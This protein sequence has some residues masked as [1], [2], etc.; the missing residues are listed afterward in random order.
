[1]TAFVK[2]LEKITSV[3]LALVLLCHPTVFLA[4]TLTGQNA[5]HPLLSA[6]EGPARTSTIE[7]FNSRIGSENRERVWQMTGPFGGDVTA[8]AIDPR[9]ADRVLIGGSDG[10]LFQS[11]NGG[12]SWQR[13][14][15]G[16]K[17]PGFSITVILF[18]QE[19]AG[20]IYVG[21]KP[22]LDLDAETN[23]GGLYVSADSGAN[24]REVEG[25]RGR[26]IRTLAQSAKDKN[27]LLAVSRNAVYRSANR[28]K[29]WERITP[30]DDPE[31]RNFHS[32]AIDP[33]DTDIIYVGTSHLP[34]KTKDGGK[35][36][37]RAGTKESGMIDDSDIMAI[38]ID[39]ANPDT[40]LMSACSGIYRTLDASN[41]WAEAP[42]HSLHQSSH[43]C[44][45]S[46]SDEA[47]I[48][49]GWND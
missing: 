11:T 37:V 26:S 49:S 45:L 2:L 1:M 46:T 31:L 12:A 32:I 36:W 35:T 27:V 14:R 48:H 28:G 15:P 38:H 21:V 5:I 39:E 8:L 16:L 33:R 30:T 3:S 22:Q 17:A 24:W 40:V 7:S 13:L 44:H 47:G 25:L 41:K 4:Q 20:T 10:Q 43:A 34:W 42:R 18:D 9:D 29:A 19:Q 23:S 6:G